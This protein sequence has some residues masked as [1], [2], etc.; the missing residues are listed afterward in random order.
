MPVKDPKG[1]YRKNR[2]RL[3]LQGLEDYYKLK[4]EC[5]DYYGGYCSHCGISDY[6]V[7]E[8]DH[9]NNDGAEHRRRDKKA[10]NLFRWLRNNNFPPEFQILCANCHRIKHTNVNLDRFWNEKL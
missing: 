5:L 4:K 10:R 8:I 1:Y 2:E 7:L 9:I 6:R 3:K